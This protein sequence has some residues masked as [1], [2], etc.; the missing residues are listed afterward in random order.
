MGTVSIISLSFFI[1]FFSLKSYISSAVTDS[2]TLVSSLTGNQ[3]II[4]K[5]GIFELGFF[6]PNKNLNNYYIG[7][8]YKNIPNQTVVWVANRINP[9]TNPNSSQLKFSNDGN[10]ILLKSSNH[11]I[12][13]TE[14][15]S[16]ANHATLLDTSNLVLTNGS[17]SIVWQSF[18]H[19]TDTHM[20]GGWIAYNK[21]THENIDITCWESPDNPAPGPF[22]LRM[23]TNGS[24]GQYESVILWNSSDIYW[25]RDLQ[26]GTYILNSGQTT[27]SYFNVT[28]LDSQDWNYELYSIITNSSILTR[29]V[30][31]S[32]GLF[33]QLWWFNNTQE[34]HSIFTEPLSQC[35][36]YSLCGAYGICDSTH[37]NICSCI[38]GFEAASEKDWESNDFNKGCVRKTNLQC[39]K[40]NIAQKDGFVKL[41]NVRL[42]GN[43]IR[44][45]VS[46]QK[47][48]ESACLRNCSCMAYSYN[49]GCLIWTEEIRNL[50]QLYDGGNAGGGNMYIRLAASDLPS[51]INSQKVI[52]GFAIGVTIGAIIIFF[53]VFYVI[54]FRRKWRT[55]T[56]QKKV[57]KNSLVMFSYGDLL[58]ITNNFSQKL[59]SGGFGSVFKGS[60]PDLTEVAVKKLEGSNQGEKQFRAEIST[61]GAIQHINLVKLRGFCSETNKKL[62]VYEYMSHGSLNF[63]LFKKESI[64]LGWKMRYQIILGIA[65]GIA[66][67][68]EECRE[69]IIHCDIKPDNILL[70]SNFCAKV[71]DFGMAKL[72]GRDFSHVLTTMRGTIGY[73]APE[74]LS[75][76][77]VT[78]KVDVYSFGM[79]LFEIICGKRNMR[80]FE[81]DG[82]ICYF[83][84]WAAKQIIDDNIVDLLDESLQDLEYDMD[85]LKRVCRIACWCVQYSEIQRPTMSQVVKIIE[86]I[87][88]VNVPPMPRGLEHLMQEEMLS[89][90]YHSSM[91]NNEV[92]EE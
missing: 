28:V 9:V 22:T 68:H 21:I 29:G 79:M 15:T 63:H 41:T 17:G 88:E 57:T 62:I 7:I 83:P 19:P 86:G 26:I 20:P 70:D 58:T 6:K 31:D 18:D 80:N 71:A 12:W 25:T 32:H 73:L 33:H 67:L 59:G 47:E 44:L 74:W 77:P 61:L 69:I 48:C 90:N 24:Y 76:Q 37:E 16:K 89:I 82:V 49:N 60:L 91:S 8:W 1:F 30:I 66:Y 56:M 65:R 27:P 55:I 50:Q 42:P 35:D 92:L 52:I 75:G 3:T 87:L 45:L 85:E 11:Q 38:Q 46:G 72:I 4:S 53:S 43:L 84:S 81:K 2:I 5:Q 51:S 39:G 36:A 64:D 13:S 14:T 34:W 10:L 23:N 40:R 78:T 54:S